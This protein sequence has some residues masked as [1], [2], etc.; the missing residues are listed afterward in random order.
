MAYFPTIAIGV[1]F[2]RAF[3]LIDP[4]AQAFYDRVIAD[5]GVVPTGLI[6]VSATFKAVKAIYGVTDI[7]Q[8]L[9]VFYDAHY[10]AYKK[11]TGTGATAGRAIEKL[12]SACGA[13]GDCVQTTLASQPLLLEHSGTNYV[14]LSGVNGNYFTSPF[15]VSNQF[16]NDVDYAICVKPSTLS[17]AQGLMGRNTNTSGNRGFSF[18]ITNTGILRFIMRFAGDVIVSSTVTLGS[19]G[20]TINNPVWLRVTRNSTN[21]EVKFFYSFDSITTNPTSVNWTQLGT[22]VTSTTGT[23][24]G[25]STGQI[26][27][28]SI[29]T[30]TG[31]APFNGEIYRAVQSAT[32]GGAYTLDFNPNNYNASVSQSTWTSST[33]EVYTRNRDVATTGLKAAIVDYT[34]LMSNGTSHAMRAASFNQNS[35]AFTNY[36]TFAKFNNTVTSIVSELGVDAA[37]ASGYYHATNEGAFNT[38][39]VSIY[40]NVGQNGS[41]YLNNSTLLRLATLIGDTTIASPETSY[42]SNNVAATLNST[43]ASANNTGNMNGTA[44][45]L[46][47]RNN[48]VGL[49]FFN[50]SFRNL[51]LSN[52]SDNTTIRTN[53]YNL[54]RSNYNNAF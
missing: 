27:I 33:G 23:T 30:D 22:T 54:I 50:G 48:G 46:F 10:L 31:A 52:Q 49:L 32:I 4:Q 45:N 44:L 9:S 14:Y 36:L 53:I 8:A 41:S 5:G 7:T 21:G 29:N 11:G 35:A 51:L 37:T 42:F 15:A 1:P 3:D 43:Y 39:G 20:I 17:I 40:G 6:G 26:S 16:R 25:L 19:V 13:I 18:D 12:Y 47:A 24:T 34:M 28:G 2:F 38:D